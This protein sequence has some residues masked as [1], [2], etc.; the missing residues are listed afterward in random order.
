MLP[1]LLLPLTV[2]VIIA[3]VQLTS[4]AL[5]GADPRSAVPWLNLLVGFDILFGAVCYYSFGALLEE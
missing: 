1:L 2:P 3:A 5:T 4:L